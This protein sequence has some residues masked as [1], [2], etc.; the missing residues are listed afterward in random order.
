VDRLEDEWRL[1]KTGRYRVFFQESPGDP[2]T[3][4]HI[5]RVVNSMPIRASWL[6]G[7]V[8]TKYLL[9]SILAL[10][11]ATGFA[12]E[13]KKLTLDEALRVAR[14]NNGTVLAAKLNYE[15][16][17]ANT[18]AAYAAF[19]PTV[20]PSVSREDG[21]LNTLT[22][23]NQGGINFNTT[24]AGVQAQWLIFDNGSRGASYRKSQNAREQ[25]EFSSLDT[26]RGV[27]FGVHSAFYDALRAQQLLKVSQSALER[28][29]R[30]QDA[31]EK[32]EQFGAGPR[33]DILQAKADALNAKVSLLTATNQISNT[34]ADL[35]AILG[36]N[37]ETLPPLDDSQ[38]MKPTMVDYSLERAFAEG[39]ANRPSLLAAKKRVDSSK[40]DV[41]LA[42]LDAGVTYQAT[43]NYR[44]SFSE[45]VFDRP[46]LGLSASIPLFDGSR[47]RENA[48]AAQFGLKADEATLVQTERDVRAEIESSYKAF[49]QNFDRLDGAKLAKEAAQLNFEAAE[50]AYLAGAGTV[51]DQLAAQVSLATAESNFIQAYYDL[52]ISEVRLKQVVGQPLPGELDHE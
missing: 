38:D 41:T 13:T 32:R 18:K 4:G 34:I 5:V 3:I 44:K 23:A 42:R 43:A 12:Q 6:S 14:Q 19:L 21:R 33:K 30:L 50:G 35:K 36:W 37:D 52:L 49:K 26:Y 29:L 15:V 17:K 8:M 25:V 48:K 51:L 40:L 22:G 45:G 47:S 31:A 27:L 39:L 2:E 10:G 46:S 28:A 24:E 9:F 16:A 11:S 7:V 20:T 1:L